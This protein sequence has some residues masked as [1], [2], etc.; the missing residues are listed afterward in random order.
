MR[1]GE[2]IGAEPT[3]DLTKTRHRLVQVR[4][5]NFLGRRVRFSEF[6]LPLTNIVSPAQLGAHEM[7]QIAGQVQ[8]EMSNR[9]ARLQRLGPEFLFG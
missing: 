7:I 8:D 5:H 2:L 1:A 3:H 6:A 9:V 4:Q